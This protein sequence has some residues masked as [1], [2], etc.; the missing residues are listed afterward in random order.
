MKKLA[1]LIGVSLM[2]LPCFGQFETYGY[3]T[4]SERFFLNRYGIDYVHPGI[5][6]KVVSHAI[7]TFPATERSQI[8]EAFNRFNKWNEN[9]L[10]VVPDLSQVYL[11]P[12]IENYAPNALQHI[13]IAVNDTLNDIRSIKLVEFVQDMIDSKRIDVFILFVDFRDR[14]TYFPVMTEFEGVECS[15]CPSL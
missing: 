3:L 12:V 14:V 5:R 8:Q 9:R 7:D 13:E 11:D 15:Q 1:V 6:Y 4:Q 2:S 10:L